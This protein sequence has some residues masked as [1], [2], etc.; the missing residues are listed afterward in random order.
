ML[1]HIAVALLIVDV[2]PQVFQILKAHVE[3]FGGRLGI[4]WCS[5]EHHCNIPEYLVSLPIVTE[6]RVTLVQVA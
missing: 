3:V 5:G 2:L 6:P 1:I 4:C